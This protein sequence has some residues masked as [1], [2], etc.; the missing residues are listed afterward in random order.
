MISGKTYREKVCKKTA[1]TKAKEKHR[2][3]VYET[4]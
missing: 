2:K 3:C 4:N 1:G